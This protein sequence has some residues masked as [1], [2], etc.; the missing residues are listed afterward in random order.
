M[1]I[2]LGAQ[3]PRGATAWA[4]SIAAFALG[5]F[6][7]ALTIY[8][9]YRYAEQLTRALGATGTQVLLRLSAFILLCIG[10]Q[11]VWNGV[12]ALIG[13]IPSFRPR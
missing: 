5:A 3:A 8:L 4:I 13:T 2:T 1:A 6:L 9:L 11:I 7:L 12:F 10:V